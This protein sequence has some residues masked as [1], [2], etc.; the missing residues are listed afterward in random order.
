MRGTVTLVLA[1]ILV[2]V[3]LLLAVSC[4][5]RGGPAYRKATLSIETVRG[6]GYKLA[7]RPG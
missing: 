2:S 1:L 3:A 5:S 4:A 6:V 7:R